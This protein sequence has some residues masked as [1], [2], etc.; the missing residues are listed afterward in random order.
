[1][2]EEQRIKQ[3]IENYGIPIIPG[4]K[5]DF[6]EK[7]LLKILRV[8]DKIRGNG[9]GFIGGV[10]QAGAEMIAGIGVTGYAGLQLVKRPKETIHAINPSIIY[11]VK[12]EFIAWGRDFKEMPTKKKAGYVLGFL[13][14]PTAVGKAIGVGRGVRVKGGKVVYRGEVVSTGLIKQKV[15]GAL[16]PAEVESVNIAPAGEPTLRAEKPGYVKEIKTIEGE[17]IKVQIEKRESPRT[18]ELNYPVEAELR[19]YKKG[20]YAERRTSEYLVATKEGEVRPMLKERS[21][22]EEK[23]EMPLTEERLVATVEERRTIP[24]IPEERTKIIHEI[25]VVKTKFGGLPE[26]VQRQ[27]L[28]GGLKPIVI[29]SEGAKLR[30][31]KLRIMPRISLSEKGRTAVGEDMWEPEKENE[32]TRLRSSIMQDLVQL[33]RDLTINKEKDIGT[34]SE[35]IITFEAQKQTKKQKELRMI[36]L[37]GGRLIRYKGLKPLKK[38]KPNLEQRRMIIRRGRRHKIED[39][40]RIGVKGRKLRKLLFGR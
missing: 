17:G 18:V 1:M 15:K 5:I 40:W 26:I 22:R 20:E 23:V 21:I 2:T 4:E 27:K 8:S 7:A 10:R 37:P 39:V 9:K 16:R 38:S 32:G 35:R 25:G 28:R 19:S 30:P 14:I 3:E 29:V 6:E 24:D 11:G 13:A 33:S 31:P 36:F 34:E 12:E